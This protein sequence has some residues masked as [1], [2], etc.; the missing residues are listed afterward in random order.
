MPPNH[1]SGVPHMRT[2]EEKDIDNDSNREDGNTCEYRL[3]GVKSDGPVP[4]VRGDDQEDDARDNP[5]K[6]TE[7]ARHILG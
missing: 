4:V 3:K 5:E 7:S 1:K 6:I 2:A